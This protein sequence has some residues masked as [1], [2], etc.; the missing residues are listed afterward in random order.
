M[1]ASDSCVDFAI[2]RLSLPTRRVSTA[3]SLYR[4]AMAAARDAAHEVLSQGT[5]DYLKR[6]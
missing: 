5:F 6:L 3:T 1:S 4:V 2:R